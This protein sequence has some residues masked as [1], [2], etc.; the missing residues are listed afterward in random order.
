MRRVIY[1]GL[2]LLLV[3]CQNTATSKLEVPKEIETFIID[4]VQAW[5]D[6]DVEEITENVYGV[7]LT[8]YRSDNL[9]S[10][11]SKDEIRGFLTSTFKQLDENGYSHSIFNDWKHIKV[12]DG[13][14]IVEQSFTRYLNDGSVMGAPE[15]TAS[16]ILKRNEN[17]NYRIHGMIPHTEIAE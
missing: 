4:Y 10:L 8:L 9:I 2:A 1:W 3:S 16:Y 6:G 14:A 15:R 11:Q 7:P 12:G 13:V 5:S 17:G